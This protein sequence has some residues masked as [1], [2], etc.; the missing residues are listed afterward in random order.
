MS[1]ILDAL[2]R[3]DAERERGA[4]PGLHAQPADMALPDEPRGLTLPPWAWGLGGL[5]LA[6]VGMLAWSMWRGDETPGASGAQPPGM[7][8]QGPG[9]QAGPW[10]QQ[11]ERGQ[12]PMG[13]A[14]GAWGPQAGMHRQHHEGRL[15][16]GEIDQQATGDGMG[17]GQR[18]SMPTMRREARND[19]SAMPGNSEGRARPDGNRRFTPPADI[20]T[21]NRPSAT[22][23]HADIN[24][25]APEVSPPQPDNGAKAASPASAATTSR[26]YAFH[27]LPDSVRRSVPQ[28]V[29]G[30]AMYSD[31]PGSR[32]QLFHEGDKL[33]PDL[34][35]EEIK[36]KSAVLRYKTWRY[37][38]TY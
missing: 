13:M 22:P 26:V 28:L 5:G 25:A 15:A 3:A 10:A 34:T 21:A 2:K 4:V 37:S 31:N 35:L 8:Q 11:G 16:R 12:P 23:A 6:L 24:T 33:G 9:G 18:P 14:S 19:G 20:A 30:G 38:V 27:E 32:T 1:Y 36:L 29:I 7:A 17:T